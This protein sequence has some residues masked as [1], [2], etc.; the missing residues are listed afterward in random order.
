MTTLTMIYLRDTGHALAGVTRATAPAAAEP[1]AALV[2][3]G[4]PLRRVGDKQHPMAF[5]VPADRLAA[6]N[7]DHEPFPDDPAKRGVR[8]RKQDEKVTHELVT[9]ADGSGVTVTPAATGVTVDV[10]AVPTEALP[11]LVLLQKQVASPP[12]PAPVILSGSIPA[13]TTQGVLAATLDKGVWNAFAFVRGYTPNGTQAT[14][15]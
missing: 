2:G 14:L 7:F 13:F 5:S 9:L 1:V 4:L 10:P 12:V 15:S 11:V 8:E 3:P 6:A